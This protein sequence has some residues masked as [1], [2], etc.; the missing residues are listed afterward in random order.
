MN[1]SK[2]DVSEDRGNTLAFFGLRHGCLGDEG[3][4]FGGLFGGPTMKK[5]FPPPYLHRKNLLP[6][7]RGDQ[8][9]V[10]RSNHKNRGENIQISTRR[11][12]SLATAPG[13]PFLHACQ[14]AFGS[15]FARGIL[16]AQQSP[17][18]VR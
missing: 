5:R 4:I 14:C 8:I 1:A 18:G 12:T 9:H 13:A 3:R 6:A 11:S 17:E 15:V 2:F 10:P 16:A 7:N